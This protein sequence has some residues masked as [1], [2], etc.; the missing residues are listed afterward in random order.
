ML[1]L[2]AFL[3]GACIGSFINVVVYRV[4]AGLSIVHPPSRCPHCLT[5]LRWWQN[6]PILGW[7]LIGGKC[8]YCKAPVSWRY[9]AIELLTA[10]L[11]LGTAHY[12]RMAHP[13]AIL[14]YCAFLGWLLALALIDLDTML[15]PDSLTQSGL[16]AGLGFHLVW[17]WGLGINPVLNQIAL[18]AQGVLFAVGGAVVGIW[19]L[20]IVRGLGSWLLGV[21]AMGAGDPRLLA[22]I[23][24]WLG[25]QR[26]VVVVF[27]ASGIG[28]GMALVM[29]LGRGQAFPF[30]PSLALAG[31]I[32]LF[33]GTDI[34]QM[35][36]R[37]F[38]L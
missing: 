16:V 33:M 26:V 12:F 27:L 28:L 10:L 21:E 4:P 15:L 32:T 6:L 1:E 18:P 38:S 5:P 8:F 37:W 31:G 2:Q 30:G 13:V 11:F 25:W 22:M 17:A 7:W 14:G 19:L 3:L 9:P 36:L 20:D 35:Y 34:L 24:A 23:G 29:R